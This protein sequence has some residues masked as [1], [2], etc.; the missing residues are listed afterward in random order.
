MIP[1]TR[2]AYFNVNQ[3]IYCDSIVPDLSCTSAAPQLVRG[4]LRVT[5]AGKGSPH[6]S[7]QN[8]STA[9]AIQQQHYTATSK[10][11]THWDQLFCPHQRTWCVEKGQYHYQQLLF[12]LVIMRFHYYQKELEVNSG[13]FSNHDTLQWVSQHGPQTNYRCCPLSV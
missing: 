10:Q 9:S 11:R 4:H 13:H 3:I 12:G 1:A 5:S 7:H 6:S 8:S 2:E